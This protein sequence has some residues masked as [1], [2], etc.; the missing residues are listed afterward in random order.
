MDFSFSDLNF[1]SVEA[2]P[3][4]EVS[5]VFTVNSAS[6]FKDELTLYRS[7]LTIRFLTFSVVT[8]ES[9]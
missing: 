3:G 9:A 4:F 8:M 7:S 5:A 2:Y 1:N 6:V